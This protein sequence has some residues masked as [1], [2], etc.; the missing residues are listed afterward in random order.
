VKLICQQQNDYVVSVKANQ[1]KL[2]QQLRELAKAGSAWSVDLK[3]ES[4]RGRKTQRL[5]SVFELPESIQQQWPGAQVGITVVRWGTRGEKPY[6]EQHYYIS[7]WR[8]QAAAL[9]ERIRAHWGIE[10]PLHWV[11][12]V[13]L[14]EDHSSIAA[15]PAAAVMG[16]VRNLVITLFRRAGHASI[17]DAIDYFGNDLDQ[18]LP[19]LE[20]P[21]G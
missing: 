6:F 4:T 9:G 21:S 14:G 13:V 8:E 3:S 7:S 17:T 2:Y 18:L 20:F 11:K 12:D 15:K 16:M 1:K 10:N 5:A 19:M